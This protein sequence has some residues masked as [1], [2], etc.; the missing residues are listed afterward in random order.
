MLDWHDD[1]GKQFNLYQILT[2]SVICCTLIAFYAAFYLRGLYADGA[3]LLL[4]QILNSGFAYIG[5]ARTGVH[6]LQEWPTVL[7]IRLGVSDAG[8]LGQIYSFTML[9]TPVALISLSY[10]FLP[11]HLKYLFFFPVYYYLAGVTSSSLAAIGEAQIAGA[12]FWPLFFLLLFYNPDHLKNL[13]VLLV[14][15]VTLCLHEVYLFIAPILALV[16][17]YRLIR[18]TKTTYRVFFTLLILLFVSVTMLMLYFVI[19]TR[20]P[21]NRSTFASAMLKFTYVFE[22]PYVNMPVVLGSWT[23]LVLLCGM[24]LNESKYSRARYIL[25]LLTWLMAAA[26]ALA[27]L[28][29]QSFSPVMQFHARSYSALLIPLLCVPLLLS[30][31]L[32]TV[33]PYLES[34]FAILIV[35]ALTLGQFGWHFVATNYWRD[36]L[37]DFREIQNTHKGLVN[38]EEAL[39]NYPSEAK[40]NI[41]RM[42]W[43]WTNPTMS[44]LLSKGG[45]VQTIIRN[46]DR[47]K[48]RW[49]PFNPEL[50]NKSLLKSR[51]FNFSEYLKA[52]PSHHSELPR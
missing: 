40:K 34:A 26:T 39:K 23:G 49:E 28:V 15:M 18:S 9:F 29:G 19:S 12:Y 24:Y 25:I 48:G 43:A 16:S 22:P 36:Y 51:H 21:V 47:N 4:M 44:I 7:L 17:C 30:L 3:H 1:G 52:L 2:V 6:F 10:F 37:A 45:N 41:E 35:L 38:F 27:P 14:S 50:L 42:T 8:L 46:P 33:R 20:D 11:K 32:S 31:R 5:A 13:L